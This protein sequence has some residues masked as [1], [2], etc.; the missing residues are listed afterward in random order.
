MIEI[1]KLNSHIFDLHAIKSVS[2]ND[3]KI[4]W[5]YIKN[6]FG[7]DMLEDRKTIMI[8]SMVNRKLLVSN[9]HIVIYRPEYFTLR[10]EEMTFA[11]EGEFIKSNKSNTH[12][13]PLLIGLVDIYVSSKMNHTDVRMKWLINTLIEHK[14]LINIFDPAN[15]TNTTFTE[16]FNYEG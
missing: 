11:A 1:S 10:L 4:A 13:E 8:N 16:L 6:I 2:Q 14:V 7:P 5:F 3:L 9:D 12:L 15:K